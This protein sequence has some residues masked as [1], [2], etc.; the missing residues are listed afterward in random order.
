METGDETKIRRDGVGGGDL[1]LDLR[2]DLGSRSPTS[3][4]TTTT[5]SVPSIP[6]W[7][8]D[9]RSSAI[10][11]LLLVLAPLVVPYLLD[12][13]PAAAS[14]SALHQP[15]FSFPGVVGDDPDREGFVSG[16]ILI[17]FSE[18][19]DKTFFIALLLALQSSR[20]AV[21]VGTFGALAIMTVIS[22]GLGVAVH[23]VD[24]LLPA[25]PVPWDDVLS[26]LLLIWFGIGTLRGAADFTETANEELEEAGEVLEESTIA[27][28]ESLALILSTFTLVF[29]AEWGDKSFLATI[30]LAAAS[31]PLGVTG[32][33]IAGHGIATALAVT[34]GSVMSKVRIYVRVGGLG[35][36]LGLGLGVGGD[37]ILVWSFSLSHHSQP[38][39]TDHV[40]CVQ[41]VS[42][43]AVA[44]VGGGLFLL[45]AAAT[46]VDIVREVGG[47]ASF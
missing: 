42:E 14:S 45:F 22:V 31:S 10:P 20:E 5:T 39:L 33:A 41:Y 40:P 27:S 1:D 47:T 15:S 29:A 6:W 38:I 28:K 16:F 35:L 21:F 17:L 36:G 34:G 2:P 25:S 32:G 3:P 24:E 13:S 11:L 44:Y 7:R 18:L 23:S 12:V 26:V 19:G 4:T 9:V 43:K 46:T 8:T 30:A 37:M